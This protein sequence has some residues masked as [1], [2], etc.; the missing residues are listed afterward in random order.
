[1]W[2][3]LTFELLGYCG[4]R[5]F[6]AHRT[7]DRRALIFRDVGVDGR[8]LGDLMPPRRAGHRAG[9]RGQDV[10]TMATRVGKDFDDRVHALGR[11][12]RPLMPGMPRLTTR[13]ATTL[14]APTAL[15]LSAREAIG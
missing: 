15:A 3:E 11:H 9:L 8:P 7:D 2:S 14:L 13:L 5:G 12:L 6:P 10:L 1:M 4:L